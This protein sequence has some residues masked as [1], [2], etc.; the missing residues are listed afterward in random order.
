MSGGCGWCR[1]EEACRGVYA[2]IDPDG[3]WFLSNTGLIDMGDYTLVIDTQYNEARARDVLALIKGLGLPG[4]ALVVN[5]HHHGDHAWGNHVFGV[6]AVMH[7][8]AAEALRELAPLA[9]DIYKPFF[10]SLDFTGSRYTEPTIVFRD[11]LVLRGSRGPVTLRHLGPAHTVGDIV[12][13]VGWCDTV[14]LGDL[15]FNGVTPLALD[16]TLEGWARVARWIQEHYDGRILVG[17]HGPPGTTREVAL[18]ERYLEHVLQGTREHLE[19]GVEDPLEI[20][21][22]IGPGPLEGWSVPERLVLNVARAI[23]DI[24]GEPPGAPVPN[25]A[26]L[27]LKMRQYPASKT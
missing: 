11:E 26:E 6:H 25:L 27:A 9:P 21:A 4:D 16:G 24:R 1:V 23:M 2:V 5:T 10:P 3:G 7:E 18:V 20:A 22:S 13:E 17:G 19:R 8:R 15:L 14:F 12:V